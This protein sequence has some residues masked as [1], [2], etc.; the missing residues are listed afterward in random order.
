VLF[1]LG[2]HPLGPGFEDETMGGAGGSGAGGTGGAAKH[3][4]KGMKRSKAAAGG[5]AHGGSRT[6]DEHNPSEEDFL[7][8]WR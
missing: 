3:K 2:P 1:R 5:A 7:Q 8:D 6:R 4:G